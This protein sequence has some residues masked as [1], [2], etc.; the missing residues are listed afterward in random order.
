LFQVVN[1]YLLIFL[2]NKKYVWVINLEGGNGNL[3]GTCEDKIG[4][5]GFSA[6]LGSGWISG[7]TMPQQI[8][9]LFLLLQK[10]NNSKPN[11][12]Y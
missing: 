12:F 11:Y 4:G 3:G 10:I 9:I 2:Q 1:F 5:M 6:F 7:C 8:I